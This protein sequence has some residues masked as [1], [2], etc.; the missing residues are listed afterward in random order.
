MCKYTR[1][2]PQ[3]KN[4]DPFSK[5]S[6]ENKFYSFDCQNYLRRITKRIIEM[7]YLNSPEIRL[8]LREW[9]EEKKKV[10]QVHF[11]SATTSSSFAI[12]QNIFVK[13]PVSVICHVSCWL[14]RI[15]SSSS[16]SL[17]FAFRLV[18]VLSLLIFFDVFR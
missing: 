12:W 18:Y 7:V 8:V 5:S 15:F 3:K 6:V 9:R 1:S 13:H 16:L 11:C 10:G 2:S 4:H 14:W 17:E